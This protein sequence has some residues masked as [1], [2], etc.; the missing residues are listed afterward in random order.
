MEKTA[1]LF[2]DDF[3]PVDLLFIHQDCLRVIKFDVIVHQIT[4]EIKHH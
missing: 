1:I 2:D 3:S 4:L